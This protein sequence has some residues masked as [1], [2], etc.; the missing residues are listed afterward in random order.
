LENLEKMLAEPWAVA[1]R[2]PYSDQCAAFYA[3][4]RGF[5]PVLIAKLFGVTPT[6]M[7]LLRNCE[8]APRR[9]TKLKAEYA[10]LGHDAFGQKYWTD[11]IDDRLARF[12]LNVEKQ[13]DF[14]PNR[15]RGPN[16]AADS[17]SFK[18]LRRPIQVHSEFFRIDWL[19]TRYVPIAGWYYSVCTAEGHKT[20]NGWTWRGRDS[21]VVQDD[22]VKPFERSEHAEDYL[23]GGKENNPWRQNSP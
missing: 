6:A 14:M 5:R 23:W 17:R 18:T 19:S 4:K 11:A 12:R 13:N 15:G 9:Y 1:S 2:M 20:E 10:A 16:P 7:S 22:N 3:M 8:N 21:W